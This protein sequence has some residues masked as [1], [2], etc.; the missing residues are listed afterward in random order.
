MI[1]KP[2]T[3]AGQMLVIAISFLSWRTKSMAS[4]LVRTLIPTLPKMQTHFSTWPDLKK[5]YYQAIY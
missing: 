4:P 5:I 2:L 3:E 1:N